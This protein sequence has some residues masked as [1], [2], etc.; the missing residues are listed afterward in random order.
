[1][2]P[3]QGADVPSFDQQSNLYQ[4]KLLDKLTALMNIIDVALT[5][6]RAA[7][8]KKQGDPLRL[9]EILGNLSSTRSVCEKARKVIEDRLRIAGARPA[10]TGDPS[11]SGVSYREYVE[12]KDPR[13]IEKFRGRGSISADEIQGCDLDSLLKR[14]VE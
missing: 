4:V 8:L 2:N 11:A 14:L 9:Q 1:M 6:A 13:E 3:P 12:L 5:R 10:P 7:L